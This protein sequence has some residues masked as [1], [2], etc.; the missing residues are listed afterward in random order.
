VQIA[1]SYGAEVTGVCRTRNVELVQSVGADH[2]IDYTQQD[3]AA[4][5]QR[6]DVVL[7]LVGNRSLSE[8]RRALTPDGTLLLSG[9][10][11][12]EGGSLV[13]PM[14]LFIKAQLISR[15]VHQRILAFT[16]APDKNNLVALR[17]LA[18]SG[19]VAPV[20]DRSFALSEV[21]AAIRYVEV[22]HARAKVVITV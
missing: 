2:V 13:G 16:Q 19:K 9:G 20:I 22:E 7:D 14:A 18:E 10:G 1:K 8:L 12:S 15:F 6:Y 11:V 17:E 3:F 21:P 4:N 5:G